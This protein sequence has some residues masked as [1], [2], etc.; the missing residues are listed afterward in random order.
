M[1]YL[2]TAHFGVSNSFLEYLTLSLTIAN[3]LQCF[4]F[5]TALLN[6]LCFGL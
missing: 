3:K 6:T 2:N 4:K 1:P 5:Y